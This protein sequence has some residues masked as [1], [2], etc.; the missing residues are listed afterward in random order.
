MLHPK[1]EN[2]WLI[3]LFQNTPAKFHGRPELNEQM[4]KELNQLL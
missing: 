4:T 1:R 2:K 3:Q